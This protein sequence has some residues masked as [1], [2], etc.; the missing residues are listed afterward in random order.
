[1][2]AEDGD[3]NMDDMDKKEKWFGRFTLG[4][5]YCDCNR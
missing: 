3:Q 1:M 2:A 4:K 5:W